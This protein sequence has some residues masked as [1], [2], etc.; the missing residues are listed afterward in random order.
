[1]AQTQNAESLRRQNA[2]LA[3]T[4]LEAP[5]KA[6]V[7]TRLKS[8]RTREPSENVTSSGMTVQPSLAPVKPAYFENEFTCW[9]QEQKKRGVKFGWMRRCGSYF[10]SPTKRPTFSSTTAPLRMQSFEIVPLDPL[11]FEELG[12]AQAS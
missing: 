6:V 3:C 8:S 5:L 2:K 9:F 10:D 12:K 4:T 7:M 1:M 11:T